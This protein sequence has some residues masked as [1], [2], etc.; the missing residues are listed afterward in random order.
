[1]NAAQEKKRGRNRRDANRPHILKQQ[2]CD[3]R[4]HM[5]A[6]SKSWPAAEAGRSAEAHLAGVGCFGVQCIDEGSNSDGQMVFKNWQL[7]LKEHTHSEKKN[8]RNVYF[9]V[10]RALWFQCYKH[11]IA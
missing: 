9:S 6:D 10:F 1:M 4:S 2:M 3:L 5:L 7:G 8:I 11:G